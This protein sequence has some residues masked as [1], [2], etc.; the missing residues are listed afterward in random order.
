MEKIKRED[1]EAWVKECNWLKIGESGTANGQQDT[2]L[3]PTGEFV[4]VQYNLNGELH[5]VAKPMPA[6]PQDTIMRRPVYFRG[7]SEM[8]P[9][10][11]G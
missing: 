3:T 6:P 7:G 2:Y 4:I 11:P 8:P 10:F 9:G 1:F 5:Q